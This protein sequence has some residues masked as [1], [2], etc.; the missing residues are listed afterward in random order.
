MRQGTP[1]FQPSTLFVQV[2]KVAE[3]LWEHHDLIYG[4]FDYYAALHSDMETSTDEP[5]VFSISFSAL[6]PHAQ[7]PNT[8][9]T[10]GSTLIE[11]SVTHRSAPRIA[12]HVIRERLPTRLQAHATLRL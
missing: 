11:S 9:R 10:G 5:D 7:G 12:Q 8:H 6:Y 3:A 2:G 1:S 4:A